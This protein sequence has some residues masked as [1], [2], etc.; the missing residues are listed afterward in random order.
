MQSGGANLG[1][2]EIVDWY[3]EHVSCEDEYWHKE[4]LKG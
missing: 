4:D 3:L 1:D 2:A